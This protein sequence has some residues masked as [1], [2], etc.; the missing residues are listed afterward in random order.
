MKSGEK[1]RRNNENNIFNVQRCSAQP[2]PVAPLGRSKAGNAFCHESLLCAGKPR[3]PAHSQLESCCCVPCWC[4]ALAATSLSWTSRPAQ[5]EWKTETSCL[6]ENQSQ[7][8]EQINNNDCHL[9]S[10]LNTPPTP[11]HPPTIPTPSC[12]VPTYTVST[13]YI[14]S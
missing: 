13:R 14:L 5:T 11:T 4:V 3:L 2:T 9:C 10:K 12:Y 7:W 1:K 8:H 6:S